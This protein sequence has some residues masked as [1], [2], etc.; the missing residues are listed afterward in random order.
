MKTNT[1]NNNILSTELIKELKTKVTVLSFENDLLMNQY[2]SLHLEGNSLVAMDVM[3][4]LLK[5]NLNIIGFFIGAKG[6][7]VIE[8]KNIKFV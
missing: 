7:L 3:D 8:L 2:Y 6:E 1:E 5:Y 4:I